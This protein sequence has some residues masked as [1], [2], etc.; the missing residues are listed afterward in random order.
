MSKPTRRVRTIAIFCSVQLLAVAMIVFA[1]GY[2]A[3]IDSLPFGNVYSNC[4]LHDYL[5]LYCPGCGGTRAMVALIRGQLWHSLRCNPL[6]AYLAAG[7][8]YFDATALYRIIKSKTPVLRIPL[9]YWW[10]LL[11]LAALSFIA[12]NVLLVFFGVDYLG[13]LLPFWPMQ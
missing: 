9:W 10:V 7:F 2:R 3:L 8:L 1:F 13:D 12:R 6:S 4:P 5:H 11:A